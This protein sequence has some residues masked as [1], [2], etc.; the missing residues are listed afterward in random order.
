MDNVVNMSEVASDARP[1]KILVCTPSNAA[2]DEVLRRVGADGIMDGS[3][4][5]IKRCAIRLG[6][7]F[8]QDV[9]NHG[10]ENMVKRRLAATCDMPD[11]NRQETE[12]EK[13]LREAEILFSTLS[14][15]G[16]R[17]LVGFPGD[18]DT[19]VMD[20]ASQGLEMSTLV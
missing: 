19:V 17:D 2:V 3:A 7:N 6:P 1:R 14:V 8:A 18:I 12:K 10:L 15:S 5:A 20:E 13:L 4:R 16:S 9:V 11:L